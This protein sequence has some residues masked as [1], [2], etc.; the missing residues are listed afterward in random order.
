MA[1][2]NKRHYEAIAT[3]LQAAKND[4]VMVHETDKPTV[5]HWD[6]LIERFADALARDNHLFDRSRF[7]LAC[8]PGSN[9]K[10]RTAHL[11]PYQPKTGAACSCKRGV[12]RDNCPRC[13]G[14]GMVVDFAAIRARAAS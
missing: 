8:K 14:T 5:S 10:A 6:L 11:K 12:E 1:H 7:V 3:V 13:E 9:V 2:F 4:P